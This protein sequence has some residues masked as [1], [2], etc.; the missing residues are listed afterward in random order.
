[1]NLI[2]RSKRHS[3]RLIGTTL[4]AVMLATPAARA[5]ASSCATVHAVSLK[6][7]TVPYHLYFVDS[8]KAVAALHGGKPKV[9]EAISVGGVMY[10][11]N[12]G[13][14]M[15]S[16]VS[17][18]EMNAER[19]K[20][21]WTKD[22]CS[23]LRDESVNGEAASVW[24]LHVVTEMST[25]DTDMWISK[26]RGVVLKANTVTDLGGRSEKNHASA[27]YEYTNVRAPVGVQ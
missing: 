25:V 16:P 21:D 18:A 10:L 27:R 9:G 7:E 5:Q 20:H 11:L 17:M 3:L 24:R 13:K 2:P 12:K 14:W 4:G 8:A 6:M 26:S 19:D 22:T 15:K 1:M 23:H